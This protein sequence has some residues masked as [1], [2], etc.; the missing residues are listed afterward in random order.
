MEELLQKNEE[1]KRPEKIEDNRDEMKDAKNDMQDAK[2]NLNQ[3]QKKSASK[4][5]KSA[6]N[7]MKNM[8]N[9]MKQNSQAGE[10]EQAEEDIAA[11]RQLLENLV[12][13]SFT[14]EQTMK[15]VTNT[16]VNTP[17]Y[18]ELAQQQF[19]IKD[20]FKL[21]EDSLQ[22]LASRNFQI[23]SIISEKV[24]EIKS[25]IQNSLDEL[26]ERRVNSAT[27]YQQRSMKNLNDLALM[28]SEAMN[29]MQQQAM[30]PSACQKPGKKSKGQG[31][32]KDKMSKGQE[33]LN[34]IMQDL[35][36]RLDK[37]AKDGKPGQATS[38]EFA[39]MAAK[40][41]ALRNALREMQKQK[42]EQGKGDK[43]LDE[44][45]DA[46]NKIETDLV[47]KK[48]TNEMLR[49]QQE[50][51][52][53]LLEHEKAE[54]EREQDEQRQAETAKQQQPQ[55]PP[56]LEEYLKKRRAEIEQFRT[57]SPALKPYY[58]QLVEEYLKGAQ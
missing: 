57:V 20:D 24:T 46:M 48:L 50:I 6:A 44:I 17:R 49:R 53:R 54:R 22:A 3:K 35:K 45:M 56:A 16:T 23:E 58:K 8:A 36:E 9:Q 38:E 37:Q 2:Q 7:K 41:A 31:E 28:L 30:N 12:G 52:T 29:Q 25:S 40:Q 47:N 10:Q 34:K 43:A 39:K 11:L 4:K 1:L 5:Q 55:M 13:L 15:D 33:D 14:Q 21:V 19:K 51:L 26:E 42:Q 27:E 18:V 32:P